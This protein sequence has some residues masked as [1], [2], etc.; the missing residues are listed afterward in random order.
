MREREKKDE[1]TIPDPEK[2]KL[3]YVQYMHE[4]KYGKMSLVRY[5]KE[6]ASKGIKFET[7]EY[8]D[9]QKRP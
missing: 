7:I 3:G 4:K 2:D 5:E 9:G 8:K 1:E 6:L